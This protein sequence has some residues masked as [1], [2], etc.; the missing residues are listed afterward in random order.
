MRFPV[1]LLACIAATAALLV[2]PDAAAS[3]S[4][5]VFKGHPTHVNFGRVAAGAESSHVVLTFT[6]VSGT[7]TTNG[8]VFVGAGSPPFEALGD[9]I[10]GFFYPG[11]VCEV[12]VWFTN[13]SL[14]PGTYTTVLQIVGDN[15]AFPEIHLR[16]TALAP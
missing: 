11:Q 8:G 12:E 14:A 4:G 15:F 2:L 13:A 6:D 10:G 9:C 1:G 3:D 7:H 5:I 16:A